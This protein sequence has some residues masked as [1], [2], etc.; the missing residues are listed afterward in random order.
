MGCF[1]AT[2]GSPASL[3]R[4]CDS[5]PL[6]TGTKSYGESAEPSAQAKPYFDF[7]TISSA[8]LV[9][10]DDRFYLFYEGVRGPAEGDNGDTQ[11]ALGLARSVSASADGQWETF[12][13]IPILVDLPG[14][15]GVGHADVV[16]DK[17]ARYCIHL[18]MANREVDSNW[19]GNDIQIAA[20]AMVDMPW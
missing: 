4:K 11:F 19:Y 3:F 13:E 16:I 18:W 10:V 17:D 8:D 7:R 12:P 6:F 15:V 2:L 9:S 20:I 14:N 5:N 1:V